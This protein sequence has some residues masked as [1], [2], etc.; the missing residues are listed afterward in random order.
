MTV[1][2]SNG[3]GHCV[4]CY[5]LMIL[6]IILWG[7]LLWLALWYLTYHVLVIAVLTKQ[8]CQRSLNQSRKNVHV[9]FLMI[10]FCSFRKKICIFIC[11]CI[12]SFREEREREGREGR[13]RA[14]L[15]P[16]ASD[17]T[18][19]DSQQSWWLSVHWTLKHQ[20]EL[21]KNSLKYISKTTHLLFPA[22][23]DSTDIDS[24]QS[25]WEEVSLNTFGN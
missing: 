7:V 11:I 5:Q 20:L 6:L 8:P 13:E 22:A 15:F 2:S 3:N 9:Y 10:V 12:C 4:R 25:W 21:L 16:A 1:S 19:I 23:C 24:Q 17:S 14:L 18:D